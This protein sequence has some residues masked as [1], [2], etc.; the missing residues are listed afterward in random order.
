MAKKVMSLAGTGKQ[1]V[2]A[3]ARIM[4]D[5]SLHVQVFSPDAT[6]NRPYGA[7]FNMAVGDGV[8]EYV[9]SIPATIESLATHGKFAY[10]PMYLRAGTGRIKFQFLGPEL[11][12]GYGASGYVDNL[13]EEGVSFRDWL[14]N[15]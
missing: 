1:Y 6:F 2:E 7:S 15:L 12:R 9:N 8:A 13:N 10:V 3:Q 5:G 14:A 4:D 11:N